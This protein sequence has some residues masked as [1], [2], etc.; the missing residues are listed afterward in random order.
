MRRSGRQPCPV[1]RPPAALNGLAEAG[2][3]V[4]RGAALRVTTGTSVRPRESCRAQRVELGPH[5]GS[6]R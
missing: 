2:D 3:E 6:Q 1:S 4:V 5:P